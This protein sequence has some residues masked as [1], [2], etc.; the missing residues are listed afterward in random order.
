[1]SIIKNIASRITLV[2]LFGFGLFGCDK[3][4]TDEQKERAVVKASSQNATDAEV[5]VAGCTTCYIA[6]TNQA[7]N[8]IELYDET[9]TDWNTA[10]ALK[11]SWWPADW[12]GFSSAEIAAWSNVS[13]VKVRNTTHWS[14]TSQVIVVASSGGL[15]AIAGHP[16]GLRKWAKNVGGN[17]HAAELLPNGNIAIAASTPGWIRVYASSQGGSNNTYA[18]VNLPAAHGVLWDPV[19]N[20]LWA[21]GDNLYAF[22]VGGTAANPTL[23]EIV[24][25]RYTVPG[26]GHDLSPFYGDTNKL[27][28]S[29]TSG[30]WSYNKTTKIATQAPGSAFQ[31]SVKAISNQ[32]ASG[33][34]VT[35]IP[36]TSCSLNTWCTSYVHFYSNTGLWLYDRIRTG[37]AF[38][39]GRTFNPAYQ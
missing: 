4:K 37:A 11:W 12:G 24:S 27:W 34:I 38:Y 7:N 8:R 39:K 3:I 19:N 31:S 14:G 22:T 25:R 16:N 28:F 20:C 35:T 10:A 30:T 9:V 15:V 29:E 6:T 13:D 33:H 5:S 32:T 18:Q 36:R 23:T 21:I 26:T 17:P 1:M 2:C